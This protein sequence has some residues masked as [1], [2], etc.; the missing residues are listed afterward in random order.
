MTERKSRSQSQLVEL[1]IHVAEALGLSSD[2]DL[3]E[4][5]DATVE[6]VPNWRS[7]AVQEF[8]A[9]KLKTIKTNLAEHI[10]RLRADRGEI[11]RAQDLAVVPL[12]VEEGSSPTDLQRQFRDSVSYDYL[13]HR[14]LYFE[15]MGA[16][17]WENLI[18]RGYDQDRWVSATEE[19]AKTWLDKG[20]IADALGLGKKSLKRGLDL[21]SLGPG[22]GSKEVAVLGAVIEALRKGD[23]RL[24]WLTYAPVDVSIP[25]LLEAATAARRLCLEQKGQART[26]LQVRSFCADFEEGRMLFKD[27]LPSA[28]KPD[29]PTLRLILMLGN[30]FG[31]LREEERFI[32]QRLWPLMRTGDLA[33]IEVGLRLHPI[34]NDP[35]YRMTM[36]D[37]GETATDANRRLLLEGPFRRFEAAT[38][39]AP[40]P[41]DV[42]IWLRED[43]DSARV[44]GSINFCHDLVLREERRTCTMLYSRRYDVEKLARW[45]ERL[46]LEVLRIQRVED[47][48]KRARVAHLLLRRR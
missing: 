7:G 9:Q 47:D 12:E 34:E 17:A 10:E 11:E 22:E 28:Q 21:I 25:L 35:L 14:F 42:R 39:R 23:D 46:D 19:F 6:N 16:L 20:P 45:F 27:R 48:K 2:R 1:F 13:G 32:R 38:G 4:L 36:G 37:R 15:A 33:W 30:T 18:K 8:K 3:A 40:T 5:A 26:R 29:L 24:G 44:P 31:N 43:D 41:L